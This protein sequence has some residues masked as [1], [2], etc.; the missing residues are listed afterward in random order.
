MVFQAGGQLDPR[1]SVTLNS[2]NFFDGL[3]C[4][5]WLANGSAVHG[6]RRCCNITVA[7]LRLMRF[8][9]WTGEWHGTTGNLVNRLRFLCNVAAATQRLEKLMGRTL[10]CEVCL[11]DR[12]SRARRICCLELVIGSVDNCDVLEVEGAR[13]EI[14]EK[15][16]LLTS[17]CVWMGEATFFGC[18]WVYIVARGDFL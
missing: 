1:C 7:T 4:S 9:C 3:Y 14:A 18:S 11:R 2:G 16:L 5:C 6:A 13:G 8:F 15:L 12:G 10:L 17:V